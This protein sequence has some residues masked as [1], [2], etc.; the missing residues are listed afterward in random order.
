MKYQQREIAG[1]IALA[2]DQMPVVVV[3][4]TRQVGKST[5][6]QM[7]PR[8]KG[9]RYLTLDD[10]GVLRTLRENPDALLEEHEALTIDEAQR[11]PRLFASIKKSVDKDRRAGRFL[12][13]GSA[14][15]ALLRGVSESLAGRAVYMNLQPMNRRELSGRAGREPFLID[16]LKKHQPPRRPSEAPLSDAEVSLGGMPPVALKDVSRPEVWFAGFEQTYLERDLRDVASVENVLGFRDLLKLTALRTAQILN[17]AEL[18]RD[19][20]LESKTASRYLGWMEATF[21]V[22]RVPPYLR[23]RASRV[24]KSS[25]IFVSDSGLA[26]YLSR[27]GDLADDPLRGALFETYVRQNIE[28]IIGSRL[29]AGG[30]HYWRTQ[31]GREVDFVIEMGREVMA[32]EVK[33]GESWS[34]SDLVG[35]QEFLRLTPNC[36]AAV[37]AY[38]GR[39]TLRLDD[40]LWAIPLGL[41][42]S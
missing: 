9:R 25:K 39:E 10:Y 4:G 6:V 34:K 2:L 14:N 37:L 12:L 18:G 15:P 35:L 27:C 24:K 40:R 41:L 8:L 38:N 13:T 28:S 11:A 22:A 42:L 32:I 21:V 36:V 33:S 31:S 19:A 16:F 29:P 1:T 17:V 30:L 3:T 26:C 7:D 23:N 20:K 5:L